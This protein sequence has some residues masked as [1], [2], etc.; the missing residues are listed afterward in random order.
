MASDH[1][2]VNELQDSRCSLLDPAH[3]PGIRD[4]VSV[5]RPGCCT[6]L[7]YC[8]RRPLGWSGPSTADRLDTVLCGVHGM[9]R[10]DTN[11]AE[12]CS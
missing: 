4:E 6:F 8:M 9:W 5:G 3:L 7:L 2:G 12:R 11:Y 1:L 10:P